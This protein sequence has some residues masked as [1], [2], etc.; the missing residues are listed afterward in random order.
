MALV[1]IKRKR[2]GR[3]LLTLGNGHQYLFQTKVNLNI[4]L[5]EEKD[6]GTILALKEA[7]C[8]G[9]TKPGYVMPTK[10]EMYKWKNA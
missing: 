8:G 3:K 4:A 2:L 9:R 7:C 1:A 5:V 10:S 6:V